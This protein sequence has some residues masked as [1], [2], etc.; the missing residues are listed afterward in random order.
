MPPLDAAATLILPRPDGGRRNSVRRRPMV[1]PNTARATAGR[2]RAVREE[3][4]AWSGERVDTLILQSL[5]C[6][7][8][9]GMLLWF[10]APLGEA[11]RAIF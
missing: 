6:S 8:M 10:H 3:I 2:R 9:G 4:R 11:L 1:V 7:A 5:I